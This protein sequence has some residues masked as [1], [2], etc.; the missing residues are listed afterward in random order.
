[1]SLQDKISQDL[2]DAMKA[3]EELRLATLRMVKADI[4]YELT[5]TGASA[6]SDEQVLGILKSN[7]KKRKE[8]AEEYR[9][10]KRDDLAQKEEEEDRIIL[11]Y[12]PPDLSEEEIR[13]VVSQVIN[14]INPTGPQD[15]GKVMGRVMQELKGKNAN[16]ALVSAVVKS[17][18]AK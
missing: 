10:A 18:I 8:T 12:L 17:M 5:K 9:K 15:T 2:K 4:Q 16:G 13:K 7:S 3:K 14:E 1:M 11:S 6:L